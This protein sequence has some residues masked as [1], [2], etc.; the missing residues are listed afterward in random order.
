M[1]HELFTSC[2]TCRNPSSRFA[3]GSPIFRWPGKLGFRFWGRLA[4][5]GAFSKNYCDKS[6]T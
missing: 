5:F 6:K 4:L 1:R 2:L 3:L